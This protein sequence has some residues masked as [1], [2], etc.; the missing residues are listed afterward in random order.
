MWNYSGWDTPAT[1]L[2]ETRAPERTFRLAALL[3]LPVLTASYVAPVGVALASGAIEWHA[4]TTGALPVIARRIGGD[5]LGHAVAAGAV[6]GTAGL[7]MA[8]LPTNSRLPSVLARDRA[9][10]AWLGVVHR[11]FGTPWAAV[12]ASAALYAIFAVF[13]FKELI[14]LNVWLYSLSLL[15]EL[16]AFLWLR[17]HEPD[18][19]RPWRMPGGGRRRVPGAL[20]ARRPRDRGLAQHAGGCGRG[21]HRAGGL[22]RVRSPGKAGSRGGAHMRGVIA[23]AAYAGGRR[24]GDVLIPDISEAL[25]EPD[26]FVWIGL[27][28]PDTELLREIQQE[29]G[30]HDLAV[31]DAL[32]AH[33][34][35]KLER[36]GDSLFVVLRP[37]RLAPGADGVELGETHI[38]V[39]PRYVVTVRHGASAPLAEVRARCEATP[40]LLAKGPGWLRTAP[41]SEEHTSELQ[42]PCNLVC[43]LLLEKKKKNETHWF[44][45]NS[46]NRHT[47]MELIRSDDSGRPTRNARDAHPTYAPTLGHIQLGSYR[48][49]TTP[50][51]L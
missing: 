30:L 31:E 4:W 34:R 15:V 8:L 21:P 27:H 42:S 26:R 23:C 45:F 20:H 39:G 17:V 25:K 11:R 12:V 2:G 14:V 6:V 13:S 18:L 46:P 37:A 22:A 47:G 5:W 24:V 50:V 28:E 51:D 29:F 41:R 10:P 32:A 40:A 36:Y 19:P 3:A 9:M 44:Y 16:A 49:A 43:R 7:S 35:P 1:V 33:Q 38:F 48:A